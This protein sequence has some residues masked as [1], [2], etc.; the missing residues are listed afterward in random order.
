MTFRINSENDK[1]G[2]KR[3]LAKREKKHRNALLA[4]WFLDQIIPR[5]VPVRLCKFSEVVKCKG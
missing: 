1:R 3:A 2:K 4:I 5:D